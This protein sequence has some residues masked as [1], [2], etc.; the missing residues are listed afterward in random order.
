MDFENATT[1]A[2]KTWQLIDVTHSFAEWLDTQPYR[3]AYF[4]RPETLSSA[5]LQSLRRHLGAAVLEAAS[6]AGSPDSVIAVLG[7][8]SLYPFLEV[9]VFADDIAQALQGRLAVFFPGEYKNNNYRLLDARDGWNYLATPIT[10]TED[11][12]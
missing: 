11:A 2:G 12:R 8:G 4:K 9:S 7:V 1:A 10:A 6:Q 5:A 3:V